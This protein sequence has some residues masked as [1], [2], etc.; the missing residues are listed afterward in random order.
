M[1]S[2]GGGSGTSCTTG[3]SDRQRSIGPCC[4]S[5]SGNDRVEDRPA[6]KPSAV[7]AGLKGH[8][9][10]ILPGPAVPQMN[11]AMKRRPGSIVGRSDRLELA[12]GH[13]GSGHGRD[14]E[15]NTE[16]VE[17]SLAIGEIVQFGEK[18]TSISVRG[19]RW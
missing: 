18:F 5:R 9:W 15:P 4:T 14:P 13:H 3:R 10:L 17:N 8:A 7:A 6:G 16:R 2:V 19:I 11:S 12:D 1:F